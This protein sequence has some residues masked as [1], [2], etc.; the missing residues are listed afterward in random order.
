MQRGGKGFKVAEPTKIRAGF[1]LVE[2]LMVV[3]FIG[4]LAVITVPKFNL[5]VISKHNVE[6]TAKKIVTDLRRARRLAI[7]DAATNEDGFEIEMIGTDPYTGY[8][9]VNKLT[10]LSVDSHTI[11]TN[12]L[13]TGGQRFIFGPLGNLLPTSDSQL[14]ISASGKTFTITITAATGMVKC[15]EN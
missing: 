5:A 11:D 9:I 1:G 3:L 2:A 7:S 10:G 4:I 14:T 15:T 12:I 6:A 13:C 8:A